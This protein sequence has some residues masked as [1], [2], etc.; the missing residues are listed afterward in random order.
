MA[1]VISGGGLGLFNSSF[2]QIGKGLGA[3]ARY[4]QGQDSQYVNIATG[5]LLLQSFDDQV[6][7]RGMTVGFSRTYNSRGSFA[8]AGSDAWLTG[9]ERRIELIGTLNQTGSVMRR[10]SGDGSYQDFAYAGNGLYR[11]TVGDGAHDSLRRD[12]KTQQWLYEEG[13]TRLEETY[14]D[15]GTGGRLTRIRDL[16]SDPLQPTTWNLSYDPQGRVSEVAANDG[17]G[18]LSRMQFTYA[19]ANLA[20]VTSHAGGETIG[21]VWYGYD[22]AGRLNTV[23]TDLT[24]GK[25]GDDDWSATAGANDGR[26]FR[27]TY[28]YVD[29]SGLQIASVQHSDGVVVSYTYDA[30][31]RVRTLTRG[32]LN[33]NDAD[34]Q[35]QTL[36]FAYDS[37]ARSTRVSDST[38]RA[39]VYYYDENNQLIAAEQPSAGG[40]QETYTYE[41]DADGNLTAAMSDGMAGT[42]YRFDANGNA[43]EQREFISS[44]LRVIARVTERTFNAANQITSETVYEVDEG[45]IL[46]L[47]GAGDA[48]KNSTSTPP[49]NALITRYLYDAA[50]RLRFVVNAA[51]EVSES[52]YA[53]TGFGVGRLL[54]SRQYLDATYSGDHS[55]AALE[56]WAGAAPRKANSGLTQYSYDAFGSVAW[57]RYAAVDAAGNGIANDADL[58]EGYRY[59]E[60]GRVL[61]RNASNG[62]DLRRTVYVYD[63]MDRLLAEKVFD[64]NAVAL[65][66]RSWAYTD[67]QRLAIAI[68]EGGAVGDGDLSNDRVRIEQRD[69]AGQVVL[70]SERALGGPTATRETRNLYD[71]A[72][73]L[74]AVQDANGGRSYLFYDVERQL[75][76]E[77]DATGALIEYVRD[78]FGRIVQ[79]VRYATLLDTRA[80]MPAPPAE[81]GL[82]Q[83]PINIDLVRPTATPQDRTVT[84][85][86]DLLGRKNVETD[87]EGRVTYFSYDLNDRLI[88]TRQLPRVNAPQNEERITRYF[89][90]VMGRELGR[91][92][93]EG[94]LVEHNYDLAGNRTRSVAYATAV[95]A[96]LREATLG[97]MRPAASAQDQVTLWFYDGRGNTLA[98]LDAEGYLTQYLRNERLA[99]DTTRAFEIQLIGLTGGETLATLLSRAQAGRVRETRRGYDAL[100]RLSVQTDPQGT[101]TRNTY[102]AQGNLVRTELAADTSEV[103]DGRLRYNVFGELTG[104]LGG[105]ASTRLRPD[106]TQAQIDA[107]F[108][109]YGTRH[110]YDGLGRRIES[111][112]AGGHKT[113]YFYDA[114]GRPTYTVR[115][116]PGTSGVLNARGE[117]SQT[118]Y[119][120]FGEAVET[121]AYTGYLQIAV[122]GSRDSVAAALTTLAYT[123]ATDT[124]RGYGYN[125][126]GQLTEVRDAENA[127]LRYGYNGHGDRT[128]EQRAFGT[129]LQLRIDSSY[130]NRGLIKTRI[131]APNTALQRQLSWSYDAFG[132]V[133]AASDARGAPT[134]FGYDRLGRQVSRSQTVQ[135]RVETWTSSYDAYARVLSQTDTNGRSTSYFY[136]AAARSMRVTTPEGIE[137]TTLYNRHG[138]QLSVSQAIPGG[139]VATT[140]YSYDRDGHLLSVTDPLNKQAFNE[141]DS[142]GLLS[143]SV[144]ASGRR[145]ELRYDAVGR[146]LQR[147]EDPQQLALTTSYVYDGQGRRQRVTDASGRVVQHRYDREGRL[148]ETALDPDNLNLRTKYSYD[149][150]GRQLTVTEGAETARARTVRYDYDLLGRRVGE[151]VD[152]AGLQLTTGYVYDGNDN[153]L[154]RYV[155]DGGNERHTQRSYYDEANRLIYSVDPT[156]AITRRWYDPAGREVA[157]R[158]Y[159]EATAPAGL[160]DATTLA[161]LNALSIEQAGDQGTYVVYD[162]DGRVRYRIDLQG[163]INDSRYDVAGRLASELSYSSAI[164]I[165][166]ALRQRLRAGTVPPQDIAALIVSSDARMVRHVYDAAGR[167]RYTLMQ[168]SA[169]TATVSER[170]FDDSGRVIAENLYGVRIPL[171]TA[172]TEAAVTTALGIAGGTGNL[173]QTR[174]VYDQAGRARYTVDDAGAVVAREYDEAGRATVVRQYEGLI[175]AATPMTEAALAAAVAGMRQRMTVTRYDNAG[176]V[177]RVTDAADQV[178]RYTYDASGLLIELLDKNGRVWTYGYDGAGRRITETSP[179]VDVWTIDANGAM[180]LQNRSIVT[181]TNYNA[182]GQVISRSEDDGTAQ[183]RVTR[184][185]YDAAGRQNRTIFPIAGRID[186]LTGVLD[187]SGTPPTTEVV[188][189]SLGRA[190]VNK[191]V[192]GRY[193]YKVYDDFGQLYLD[194]DAAGY[195]TEYEYTVFGEQAKL[196]R[197]AH[198]LNFGALPGWSAGNAIGYAQS[199]NAIVYDTVQDRSISTFYDKR[200][201]VARVQQGPVNYYRDDGGVANGIPT[202][203][204][205]YDGYGQKV[206]QSQLLQGTRDQADARWADSY[207]YY[208]DLGRLVLSVDA[209]GY[210]TRNE[211]YPTGELKRSIEYAR[212]IAISG[213]STAT[214]PG[215]PASGDEIIGFDRITHWEY[216]T[217]GR[218]YREYM[219]RH[220]ADSQGASGVSEVM[221][222]FEYDG[223]DRLTR[224]SNATGVTTTLYDALG[225]AIS[226]TEPARDVL[227]ANAGNQLLN[228]ADLSVGTLYEWVSPYTQ[229]RYDAFGNV[230]ETR[231]Y[232]N[233]LRAGT[234]VADD[235]RDQ[236]ERVRYDGQGRAITVFAGLAG[237]NEQRSYILYDAADRIVDRWSQLRTDPSGVVVRVRDH[238]DYDLAGRQT[239]ASRVRTD[240]TGTVVLATDLAESVIYNSF[241]E[242]LN[243]S[244]AGVSGLLAYGYDAAGR[245]VSDNE[246]GATRGYGYNLAGQRVRQTQWRR[247]GSDAFEAV[248]VD[249]LDRLG[250]VIA[251]RLPPHGVSTAQTASTTR[252]LDRWGN[253]L[254]LV[255][256]RG[257]RTDYRYNEANQVTRDERPLVEVVSESGARQWL[258]PVN[259][260][261]YDA[262]G[263]LVATRD[264]NG[265]TRVNVYDD[266]GR[267]IKSKDGLGQTTAF[268]FDALGNQRITQNPMGY[269][270]YKDFDALGRVVEIGDYLPNSNGIGRARAGL[271]R[272]ELNQNGDRIGVFDAMNNLVRYQYDSRGLVVRSQSAS[273]AVS[274]FEYDTQGHKIRE[275]DGVNAMTWVYD[276]HGRSQDHKNLG[277]RDFGYAYDTLTGQLIQDT[278]SGGPIGA[279]NATR[280]TTYFPDGRVKQVVEQGAQGATYRY[281]YDAAGNRTLEDATVYDVPSA[282][283]KRS[284]TRTLY[285]SH[286]RIQRVYT[287]EVAVASGQVLKRVFD[288]SYSYDAVG[289]RRSVKASAGYGANASGV[290]SNNTLPVVAQQ[291][292]PRSL[293]KGQRSEFTVLFSEVFRDAEQDPLTLEIGRLDGQ[294]WPQWLSV[295]QQANGVIR[296]VGTPDLSVVDQQFQVRLVA[297]ENGDPTRSIATTFT[298]SVSANKP[299]VLLNP[300]TE[301]VRAKTA[302]AWSRDLLASDYFSDPD[303]G[304]LLGLSVDS[305]QPAASWLQVFVDGSGVVRLRST[306]TPDTAGVHTVYLRATDQRGASVVKAVSIE[307]VQ[308]TGPT[309][310]DVLPARSATIGRDFSWMMPLSQV[311]FDADNDRLSITASGMPQGFSFLRSTEQGQPQLRLSGRAPADVAEG[312]VYQVVFT[313]TDENNHVKQATLTITMRRYNLDPQAPATIDT[314]VLIRGAGTA[315]PPLP[316]FTDSDDAVLNYRVQNLPA[317]VSF[318]P[319][320]RQLRQTGGVAVGLYDVSY[321]ADDGRGGVTTKHFGLRVRDNTAPQTP[322]FAPPQATINLAWNYVLPEFRDAE[323]DAVSYEVAGLP[324]GLSFTAG[325]R[326]IG[327]TPLA[328]GN[329]TVTVVARDPYQGSTTASFQINVAATSVNHPPQASVVSES[330][331]FPVYPR[332][333]PRPDPIRLP[334][335]L[336]T[337]PDGNPMTYRVI[338]RPA[339]FGY[340]TDSQTGEHVF[341]ANNG[342]YAAL[343]TYQLQFE[344]NDGRGGIATLTLE[345]QLEDAHARIASVG[346][347]EGVAFRFD[348]G[349]PP[350][351]QIA[352]LVESDQIEPC[353]TEPDKTEPGKGEPAG[354]TDPGIDEIEA[355][356]P[357]ETKEYW[358]TYDAENRIKINNGALVN[359][360]IQ[361]LR[362]DQESY[363]LQYDAAGHIVARMNR[364][365]NPIGG[366]DLLWI[367][368]SAFDLR[369]NRTI[370]FYEEIINGGTANYQGVRKV[371]IYDANNRVTEMRNYYSNASEFTPGAGTPEPGVTINYGGWLASAETY[372]YDIDGRLMWQKSV[373]RIDDAGNWVV[374]ANNHNQNGRQATD[375]SVLNVFKNRTEYRLGDGDTRAT[376]YDLAGRL[377]RYRYLSSNGQVNGP[378]YTATYNFSYAG[379]D[380]YQQIQ[381]QGS[382][383]AP[384]QQATTNRL[385]YDNYGRLQ[386]QREQTPL[387]SGAI[388]D[389]MRYYAYNG[390]GRV[391]SRREGTMSGETFVQD[392]VYGPGNYLLI[393]AAGEQQ[394]ELREGFTASSR[395]IQTLGG[396][397]YYSA[398]GDTVVV[399]AGERLR[400]LAQRIYGTEQLWYVLADAN[401]LGDPDQE[402]AAGS[403]LIAPDI[404]VSRNDAST[405]KPYDPGAAIGSTT[406]G[407]P[408]VT[409]PPKQHCN[410]VAMV[411][412]VVVAVVVS[413]VTY[414]AMT[415][416]AS[417]AVA[418][419]GATAGTATATAAATTAAATTATV[420]TGT[421]IAAGAVAGAAGSL[422]SQAVGSLMGVSSFSW[423]NVAAGA[424]T[425]AIT[426]G[427]GASSFGRALAGADYGNVAMAAIGSAANYVGQ[428]AAGLNV[429]FSWRN[430]AAS[431]VSSAVS[432]KI[433]GALGFEGDGFAVGFGANLTEG[434]VSLHVRQAFGMAGGGDYGSIALDAFGNA[435]GNWVAKGAGDGAKTLE[436]RMSRSMA[437]M[438]RRLDMEIER[439]TGLSVGADLDRQFAG[440]AASADMRLSAAIGLRA[441]ARANALQWSSRNFAA[442]E[443]NLYS[444]VA[445]R[446]R[447]AAASFASMA[448][449]ASGGGV[450]AVGDV[451]LIV[452]SRPIDANPGFYKDDSIVRDNLAKQLQRQRDAGPMERAGWYLGDH[453]GRVGEPEELTDAKRDMAEFEQAP[454]FIPLER[455]QDYYVRLM[456]YD[457]GEIELPAKEAAALRLSLNTFNRYYMGDTPLPVAAASAAEMEMRRGFANDIGISLLGVFAL[458]AL[459]TRAVGGN[460]TRVG[461]ALQAGAIVLD[462]YTSRMPASRGP[463]RLGSRAKVGRQDIPSSRLGKQT[464]NYSAINPGPLDDGMAGTFAGG[465]YKTVVLDQD[466]VLYRAGTES[467]PLGQ[468]FSRES[469]LGVLQTRIDK[470]VL[471]EWPGG[472]KSPIDTVFAVKIPAGTEVYVGEVGTQGGFYVGGTQ[473]IVVRKPWQIDGVQ[474]IEWKPLK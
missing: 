329:Y 172:L 403:Q 53:S 365:A 188:Y 162:G 156:G 120:A 10:H 418:G 74:R 276:I 360:Q 90:D 78:T 374:E 150:N 388:D 440:L 191:D 319:A 310:P 450:V 104:E 223:R 62:A 303:V 30:L 420:G 456:A 422:A 254:Q 1:A 174:Y 219:Q 278:Q 394:A 397:G 382:G 467:Q 20:S 145:V 432:S 363:E 452:D 442:T 210:V 168:D 469:P 408:I 71:R 178:E 474:V 270:T 54:K 11:S 339:W 461:A 464:G 23:T 367:E 237:G 121:T 372:A 182:L 385:T 6:V 116:L 359:G 249:T 4:G 227:A 392:M 434:V 14:A 55:L 353:R 308:N 402:L 133:V 400:T 346:D 59:D 206:K 314:Q 72:G 60:R 320:T 119:N 69:A 241:G 286:N 258:R 364:R 169:S 281:E 155:L 49:A 426:A 205:E 288:L 218:K 383:N 443:S 85:F 184:Y 338:N 261:F 170:R 399:Q 342:A 433:N 163:R 428:K 115:G 12:G 217:L 425:G 438:Q 86:Y 366:N 356:V 18:N 27:T 453:R 410:A 24:P 327:G 275:F 117:V 29:A 462:L 429:A 128:V 362:Y 463:V 58:I 134:T 15:P 177:E 129:A 186:P 301:V 98:M 231:R 454:E 79:T 299:P 124:R 298:L 322:A 379:W 325:S 238:Y 36:S 158:A 290:S 324:P 5:N 375:L 225:R 423:R 32:D 466:T 91:L 202:T 344:A 228:G 373:G 396:R 471:P 3:S 266:V 148:L 340:S 415:G 179:R 407:L 326:S 25:T 263:R 181:R 229:M 240:Q 350:A 7:M 332:D 267:M 395:Q 389:R 239:G 152:P 300:G 33:D 94:Y 455:V 34:G 47:A 125:R 40:W 109:Q 198:A 343:G 412:M 273:G 110:S 160:T 189:D 405:F 215:L 424:I 37:Q 211:Y 13:E 335:N 358:Y 41:Y 416:P 297:K 406:P 226:L 216:D 73:L 243:K 309:G 97:Q 277:G 141:Y 61:E 203:L 167:E 247:S 470:A 265:N 274:T 132:R 318:D 65:Q 194:I 311:F 233:G 92:D 256:V 341:S 380:S 136:D 272:Y 313:A 398:G 221:S 285:D 46:G 439:D 8:G 43:I 26:L 200:G 28:H 472:G 445:G 165:N 236:V 316:P 138:Q 197:R 349:S 348:M 404:T 123:A 31:G 468:Y 52:E 173:R 347:D 351:N 105:E 234:A 70:V 271:Q 87:A 417:A 171:S 176:R 414:G 386:S 164:A 16:K 77:V 232:A 135:G 146:V 45:D 331:W 214:Q 112:D 44:G 409:P 80:W 436:A 48:G 246:T 199:L 376:G 352:E 114:D 142:R 381:V 82:T 157:T 291:P 213:L 180:T 250:R 253:V 64:R 279:G 446:G 89:F 306:R 252:Q 161:Q 262:L 139:A 192:S 67:S 377:T 38:G 457:A 280:D 260:W 361:L 122:A 187:V 323:N 56:A 175:A 195:V 315:L 255:D 391:S 245:M 68:V 39:W 153:L 95:A 137:V 354:D 106:M 113:W 292:P 154:R 289:N 248:S 370:E 100:G 222:Q 50:N 151:V 183:A 99:Q 441:D 93:A 264:A 430:L 328:T 282:R 390:D 369:G 393:H 242:I 185:E 302:Q 371:F 312:T 118:R 66:S 444:V 147:I 378:V 448:V 269:L 284:I 451:D 42:V 108:A 357:V 401:G 84:T 235:Q 21:R 102:D 51:G 9:F 88:R 427:V 196:Y 83:V 458:P 387:T 224:L 81:P 127:V 437:V 107:V 63:G 413:V 465:R 307:V 103:R 2:S 101:L 190:V 57:R 143:A 220:F 19:G 431:A 317:G 293:R 96:N 337:D 159:L 204:Y 17:T 230:I 449:S 76:G 384:N 208:D 130:D 131:E 345:V 287:E 321:I 294:P 368:R 447:L 296:F 333:N 295:T 259:Q 22:V 144:D 212:A 334:A 193:S 473:Q 268:A 257:L 330:L 35:G 251:T 207:F 435:L 75:V 111:I 355:L 149:V 166:E 421:A 201:L 459:L 411:L 419:A 460:E 283:L 305:V 126:R 140:R 304:D 244:H 336:F 209:E